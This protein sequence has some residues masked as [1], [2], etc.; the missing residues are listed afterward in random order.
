MLVLFQDHIL[1]VWNGCMIGEIKFNNKKLINNF[2]LDRKR[3]I[4][5]PENNSNM[6][7]NKKLQIINVKISH[8]YTKTQCFRF[9]EDKN[10]EEMR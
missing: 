4:H 2:L 6:S 1:I 7:F 3:L 10:K 8:F 5:M 9:K